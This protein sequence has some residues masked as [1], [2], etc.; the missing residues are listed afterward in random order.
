MPVSSRNESVTN[1]IPISIP[2]NTGVPSP[3]GPRDVFD[4]ITKAVVFLVS[5]KLILDYLSN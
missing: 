3:E 5:L 1:E 2:I 4:G